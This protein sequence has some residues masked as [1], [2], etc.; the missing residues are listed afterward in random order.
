MSDELQLPSDWTPPT[1]AAAVNADK[2]AKR[3]RRRSR[4]AIRAGAAIVAVIVILS[5]GRF[6]ASG[7]PS[8]LDGYMHGKGVQF[9]FPGDRLSVRLPETPETKVS[10]D[11]VKGASA[12][13]YH[14][15]YEIFFVSAEA[16]L[17]TSSNSALV[18]DLQSQLNGFAQE[19]KISLEKP[20]TTTLAGNVAVSARGS[21]KGDETATEVMFAN[22]RLYLFMVHTKSGSAKVLAELEKSVA[23]R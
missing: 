10:N 17:D 1:P 18:A 13:I 9:V 8:A 4:I 5:I 2:P 16:A 7:T 14:K 23:L 12:E 21:Y 20:A 3:T 6:F 15:T 11:E 22:G 19:R